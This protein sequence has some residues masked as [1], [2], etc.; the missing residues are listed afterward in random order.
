ME[1]FVIIGVFVLLGILFRHLE[2]FPKDSAQVLNMFAL[3]VSLPALILLKAPQIAFSREIAIAAIIPWGMLLLSALLVLAGARLWHWQR[4]TVGVLL[5]V[6]PLGNTSFLGIPM[7]QAFFGA[8]GLSYLIIYDQIGT[9]MIMVTYGSFILATYG[10]NGSTRLAQIVRRVLLFPPTIALLIGLAVRAW[11]YPEKLAQA[12][13]NVSLTLVPVVMTAI[14]MQMRFRL[15]YRVLPPLG[16]GLGIKL[17]V[18]PLLALLVCRV[19]GQT[20]MVADVS[21]LEAAMPPMVTAG[22][23]AVVA[24]MD[25]DLAVA[26]IGIGIILAFGT[27]PAIFWLTKLV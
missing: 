16:F 17:L 21:I 24:G 27:L 10:K 7:I 13:Q 12:L 5:L 8:A 3:Y 14:G 23:L 19:A 25:A 2:A 9:M 26:M 1:N 6:V 15:P 4:S 11:P 18:A 20:G 22:A